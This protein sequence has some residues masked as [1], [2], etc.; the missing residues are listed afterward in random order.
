[1]LAPALPAPT[2]TAT[3]TTA[4]STSPLLLIFFSFAATD[5]TSFRLEPEVLKGFGGSPIEGRRHPVVAA[6][7]REVALSDP[8]RSAM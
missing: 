1:M 3:V 2:D 4:N 8:R 6:A 5:V 7:L